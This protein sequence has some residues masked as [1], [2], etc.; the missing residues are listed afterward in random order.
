MQI[1]YADLVQSHARAFEVTFYLSSVVAVLGAIACFVL[2]R[3]E[4]T[5]LQGPVFNRRSRWMLANAA[6][7]P[8]LTRLPPDAEPD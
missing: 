8:A 2:V 3:K 6:M 1:V 4:P 7:T 5:I